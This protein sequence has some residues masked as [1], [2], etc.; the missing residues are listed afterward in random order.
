MTSVAGS[1]P[2]SRSTARPESYAGGMLTLFALDGIPEIVPGDDLGQIIGDAAS[3]LL[4]GDIVV[5]TSKI[6][7]KAEGRVVNATDREA[8]IDAETVRIVA[9]RE[10]AGGVTRIVETRQGLVLAAA[11][12]DAS[13]TPDGTVLLLPVDPD[14]SANTIARTLRDRFRVAVGVL[15]T[16]TLG[17][18]WR[19]GQTDVAIGAAGIR[20]L[21]DLRGT[22]DSSGRRL[23]A[24][25][26]AVADEIAGA[27]DLVKGKTSGR[28]VAIV[29]GLG[30]LVGSLE[31]PGARAIVR[32]AADDMFRLGS[33][34]AWAEGF[35]AG[36]SR[37]EGTRG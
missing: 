30:H 37:E 8:A 14:A 17:R 5:V 24:T 22:R 35:R 13:N 26:A 32:P 27:A 25:I 3:E 11:G 16:D 28:P 6:V 23:D 21:D 19:E 34:E 1:D 31:L 9:T 36:S 10:H 20:V 7:S 33:A 18:P 2:V 29:R 12:V 4:D 15:V